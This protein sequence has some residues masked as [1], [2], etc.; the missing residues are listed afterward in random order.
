MVTK[1]HTLSQINNFGL[2]DNISDFL[3]VVISENR[4]DVCFFF[5]RARARDVVF[6]EDRLENTLVLPRLLLGL[7]LETR[8]LLPRKEATTRSRNDY[9]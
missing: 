9:F 4:S 2:F 5:I 3:I 8:Q 6:V 1:K 7:L